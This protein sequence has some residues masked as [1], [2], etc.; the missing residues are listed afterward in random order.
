MVWKRLNEQRN[1]VEDEIHSLLLEWK[2]Y[3][4]K[5]L[6]SIKVEAVD[7]ELSYTCLEVKGWSLLD[8]ESVD[9]VSHFLKS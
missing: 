3:I 5:C 1:C 7:Q 9:K 4:P 2:V 6:L 8:I